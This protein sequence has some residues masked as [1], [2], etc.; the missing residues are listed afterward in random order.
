MHTIQPFMDEDFLLDTEPARRLYHGYAEGRPIIDFHNHLPPQAVASDERFP[1][2][3]AAWLAG[4]HY[5]WRAMRSNGIPEELVT[6]PRSWEDKFDAWA[7]TVEKLIG[8]PLYH[9]THLELRRYFGVQD[10]LNPATSKAIRERCDSVLASPG[11]GA[12]GLLRMMNV[13]AICTTD[14]PAD[15]LAHHTSFGASRTESDPVM[16]PTFRPDKAMNTA[17]PAAWNTYADRLGAIAGTSIATWPDLAAALGKRHEVFHQ[18]GCRLSDH[19]LELP[20]FEPATDVELTSIIGTLRRGGSLSLEDADRLRTAV[21][22]LTGRLNAAKGWTM[23]LHMGAIRNLNSRMF[24]LLGPDTGF[25]AIGDGVAGKPLA[26]FLDSLD[27]QGQLPATILYTLNPTWNDMLATIMG[28]FQDGSIPGKMQF[29]SA[30]WFN[31]QLDGMRAQMQ[32]LASMG[33]LSRFVGMLTDSRSF[34]SFP[35][36]EYFRRLLC[37]ILGDWIQRGMAPAD[38]S[39]IGGMVEDIAWRNA[40]RRFA[41]PGVPL[42]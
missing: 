42:P 10:I 5:K 7:S 19:A 16:V 12:C 4:D 3:S 35:R 26:A 31:D 23:Q 9:W 27:R 34:L 32:S 24:A 6:G 13:R 37:A 15:D 30:W 20:V 18:A 22:L 8:N 39:L 11:F 17:D 28:S 14:D 40:A 2:I 25:D 38:Y 33:L 36:H 1:G 41:I 29:G 21:L